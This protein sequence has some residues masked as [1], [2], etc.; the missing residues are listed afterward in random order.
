MEAG[1]THSAAT[2]AVLME[3]EHKMPLSRTGEGLS[4][5]STQ[6]HSH[7]YLALGQEG[8]TMGGVQ[9]VA[10]GLPGLVIGFILLTNFRG[11]TDKWLEGRTLSRTYVRLIGGLLGLFGGLFV[12]VGLGRIISGDT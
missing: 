11:A 7:P 4:H 5:V 1:V 8:P 10:M 3:G 12:I 6:I 9:A 2:A